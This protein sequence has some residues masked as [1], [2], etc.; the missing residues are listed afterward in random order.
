MAETIQQWVA[1]T[2]DA[3]GLVGLAL[4]MAVENVFPPIPSELV[5]PLT[6]FSVAQGELALV[7]AILAATIGATTGALALYAIGAYGG[8]PLILRHR[9]L[10][11]IDEK[12]IERADAWFDRY[13]PWFVLGARMVPIARSLISVPAG[14]SRMPLAL[15]VTLTFVGSALW[16]SL[17]IG[18]GY[19]LGAEWETVA[20]IVG[21]LSRVVLVAG[22]GAIGAV[23][24][25]W[26]RR[27]R[28][29]SAAATGGGP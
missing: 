9:R 22:V 2:I 24:I 28:T 20:E 18:A 16:N 7:P 4:I 8:L 11:R 5:L 12:Q 25:L 29:T 21:V 19:T 15:F 17:L 1:Q 27:R 6:G 3:I 13:G 23:T 10:L 14:M 26:L